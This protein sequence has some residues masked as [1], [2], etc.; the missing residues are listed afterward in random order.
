MWER[1]DQF[2]PRPPSRSAGRPRRPAARVGGS[3]AA[4]AR[5]HLA[6]RRAH[7]Q[8][9]ERACLALRPA[10]AAAALAL[11]QP[12]LTDGCHDRYRPS[13]QGRATITP[14][15]RSAAVRPSVIPRAGSVAS[16]CS[17]APARHPPPPTPRPAVRPTAGPAHRPDMDGRFPPPVPRQDVS[18]A[19][20]AAYPGGPTASS[21][22]AHPHLPAAL[23]RAGAPRLTAARTAL[24]GPPPGDPVR[25]RGAGPR[26]GREAPRPSTGRPGPGSPRAPAVP[27]VPAAGAAVL[28]AAPGR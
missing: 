20:A 22:D 14:S 23:P 1:S 21:A 10:A 6:R 7:P 19:S 9:Q 2:A 11:R 26:R 4:D 24:P 13:A 17:P 16:V 18:R 3:D 8:E 25:T 12:P 28:R 5:A 15:R 27:A